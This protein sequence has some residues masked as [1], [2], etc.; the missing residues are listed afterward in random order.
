MDPED[1]LVSTQQGS[2]ANFVPL[3]LSREAAALPGHGCPS[4]VESWATQQLCTKL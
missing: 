2:E 1:N 3:L 4:S